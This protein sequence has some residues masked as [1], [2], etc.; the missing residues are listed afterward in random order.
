MKAA[1]LGTVILM[2][3]MT[4]WS[5]D[6][7]SPESEK[8]DGLREVSHLLVAREII[9]ASDPRYYG[10]KCDW[11]GTT[12]TDD[13]AAIQ[14]AIDAIGS[15]KLVFPANHRCK[16]TSSLFTLYPNNTSM[17]IEGVPSLKGKPSSGLV[18]DPSAPA[19]FIPLVLAAGAVT[20]DG[21]RPDILY[22]V[23]S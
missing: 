18:A 7:S 10:A 12:G 14:K 22:Q 19:P 13:T 9:T 4:A 2:I 15:G 20:I 23:D 16:I 21:D 3:A 6:G 1:A 11:N 5:L 8:K 17:H